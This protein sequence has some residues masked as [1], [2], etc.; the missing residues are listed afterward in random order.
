MWFKERK[1]ELLPV[2]IYLGVTVFCFIFCS[3]YYLFSYGLR[4][5]VLELSF[6]IPL[7]ATIL[8]FVLAA[9][10]FDVG[11]WARL[12]FHMGLPAVL[13]YATLYAIYDMA[14]ATSPWL[15]VFLLIGLLC[16]AAS[17]VLAIIHRVRKKN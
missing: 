6:L 2:W 5:R 11:E 14:S 1:K 13:I 9:T 10:K 16:F 4:S 7:G 17:L 8:L 12:A 15:F 3:V